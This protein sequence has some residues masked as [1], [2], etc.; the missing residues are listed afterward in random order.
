MYG[1]IYRIISWAI[2]YRNAFATNVNHVSQLRKSSEC[3]RHC[4]VPAQRTLLHEEKKAE[5]FI[6]IVGVF[7]EGL[8]LWIS[9]LRFPF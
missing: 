2:F 5:E 4:P 6:E 9:H 7:S 8:Y 1:S 3:S